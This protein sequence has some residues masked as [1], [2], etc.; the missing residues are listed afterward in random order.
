[1]L[2]H[3]WRTA[4]ANGWAW[5]L[6][7]QPAEATDFEDASFDLV[8]SYI[9]LHEMPADAIRKVFAEAF[10][11]L[12]KGGDMIMSD[13]TRY[14]DM[15]RLSVWKADR[16]AMFGGEPHWRESASLDLE[17]VARAAGFVDVTTRGPYPYVIQ[18]RKPA[19]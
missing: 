2:E 6:S 15:D 17:E 19:A 5:Q 16:G 13:V 8:A 4:N 12:E 14:A 18:G 10:R 1:M 7:Q 3:A 9:I 11:L